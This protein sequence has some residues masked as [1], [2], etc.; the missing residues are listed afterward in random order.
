MPDATAAK[1]N[2]PRQA[3]GDRKGGATGERPGSDFARGATSGSS[4]D[5]D[6]GKALDPRRTPAHSSASKPARKPGNEPKKNQRQ[7]KQYLAIL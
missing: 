6:K 7:C 2:C 4:L 5:R 3:A 1:M